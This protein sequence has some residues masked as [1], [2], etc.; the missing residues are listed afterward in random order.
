MVI[1]TA[2]SPRHLNVMFAVILTPLLFTGSAQFPWPELDGLRW[3]QAL[4][5]LHPLHP[6][7]PLNPLNP[8]TYVSEGTRA[9]LAPG[10]P[11]LPLWVCLVVLVASVLGFG[12]LG[13]RGFL[14]RVLD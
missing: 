8:L 9:V 6:L 12:T 2:V 4:N 1:G 5:P 7:H 10:V 3:F 14:R 11:H 13:M